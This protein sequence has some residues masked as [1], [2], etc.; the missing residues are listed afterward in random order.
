[1]AQD[2]VIDED[3]VAISGGFLPYAGTFPIRQTWVASIYRRQGVRF[4][5]ADRMNPKFMEYTDG[6][7]DMLNHLTALRNAKVEEVMQ[8]GGH[9]DAA[10]AEEEHAR[11]N[12]RTKV[13]KMDSV[14][15]VLT[16]KVFSG[17]KEHSVRVMSTWH[18]RHKLGIELTEANLKLLLADPEERVEEFRPKMSQSNVHWRKNH[19][20]LY[21]R[22]FS[23]GKW[24]FK[25]KRVH[26]GDLT[27]EAYQDLIDAES[28]TLQ[29]HYDKHHDP[30]TLR[31]ERSASVE[32]HDGAE[33]EPAPVAGGD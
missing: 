10:D 16:L 18:G 21:I 30:D 13:D 4:I 12:K 17:G 15:D 33:Q 5:K 7:V 9:Q 6:K 3:V 25:T 20:Q 19:F 31:D 26:K 32:H 22:F 29:E 14:D 28:A 23:D 8:A 1:M 27:T 11:N 24:R 2:P